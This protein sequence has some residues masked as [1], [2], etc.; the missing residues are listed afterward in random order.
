MGILY[1]GNKLSKYGFT[2]T[3]VETLGLKLSEFSEIKTISDKKN[4]LY[5]ISEML[6]TIL[7]SKN[8]NYVIIDTYSGLAFIYSILCVGLC[9]VIGINY[10]PIFRGGD[11]PNYLKGK[12]SLSKAA[13]S[14]SMI[15]IAPSIYIKSRLENFGIISKYICNA[16]EIDRYIFK[17]RS[18]CKPRLFWVRSFH[19]A[20]NPQMAIYVLLKLLK[21]YP[22]AE[23]CMVGPEK[24]GAMLDC[25]TLV[26][27]FNLVDKV[28]FAGLLTKKQWASLSVKY[29][30]FINTTDFDNQPVSVI[31]AMALGFPI[32]STNSG[33]LKYL[34]DDGTDAILVQK[35]DVN[36]MVNA[37]RS[38]IENKSLASK[39]STNARK[40][41]QTFSWHN[42]KKSWK[43][44]LL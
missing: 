23:L 34:H 31:E 38:I 33:G 21:K 37:I 36:G 11:L 9:R 8:I 27:K 16:I 15:N 42:V 24:D 28:K 20:Y 12:K 32:V 43:K 1:I 2:P 22:S 4:K 39:L 10:I 3:G 13:F 35:N 19:K 18:R 14:S 40:K 17:P 30:I 7:V 26:T 44:L 6:I 5:R 25:I 41:A 29:D